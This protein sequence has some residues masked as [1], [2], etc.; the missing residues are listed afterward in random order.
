MRA[1]GSGSMS[2]PRPWP[3]GSVPAPPIRSMWRATLPRPRN[4]WS[5][6]SPQF[7]P[8]TSTCWASRCGK[9]ATS[10]SAIQTFA[11]RFFHGRDPIGR[12]VRTN[13]GPARVIGLVRNSKYHTPIEAPIPFSYAPFRQ[14]F[15]PSLNFS[16]FV[17]TNG[18]PMVVTATMRGEALALNQD[19][20]FSTSLLA[21]ATARSLFA[22]RAAAS[23]LG[24]VGGICQ[25][26]AAVG[27]YS[28][29]SYA[30]SQRTQE[31][32]IR[33]ALGAQPRDLLGMVLREGLRLTVPGLLGGSAMD[34][35]VTPFIGGRLTGVSGGRS[36]YLPVRGGVPDAGG[37]AGQLPAC[38]AGHARGSRDRAAER[39]TTE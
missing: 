17:K 29:L 11:D 8:A 39:V 3:R 21:E 33:M 22:Q 24:V 16:V 28:V 15:A 34:L 10:P 30:V 35:A 20:V 13:A 14:R 32:G 9:A 4:K 36:A 23:L 18:D 5:F 38:V 1:A 6:T 37:R 7:R 2:S 12:T 25:L 31:I 26:L 19:A 27:L